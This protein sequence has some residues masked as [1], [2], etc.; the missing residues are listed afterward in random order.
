MFTIDLLNGSAVPRKSEPREVL[1]AAAPFVLPVLIAI[2]MVAS[3]VR[4]GSLID[5]KKAEIESLEQKMLGLED[6]IKFYDDIEGQ[7]GKINTCLSE[8][9]APINQY[10]SFSTVLQ[11]LAE[12]TPDS[13]VLKELSV[14]RTDVKKSVPD[15]KDPSKKVQVSLIKRTLRLNACGLSIFESD[16]AVREYVYRLGKSKELM[17]L[18]DDIRIV[19]SEAD[20]LDDRNVTRYKIDCLFKVRD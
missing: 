4:G 16:N 13:I 12:N 15:R 18:I 8:A 2:I 5:S 19:S 14:K 1:L 17:H 3:F 7:I 6:D 11:I 10:I 9:A 20:K